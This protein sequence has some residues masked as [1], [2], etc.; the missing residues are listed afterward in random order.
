MLSMRR[1]VKG[2]QQ[3]LDLSCWDV[4]GAV[5]FSV[6]PWGSFEGKFE[7]CVGWSPNLFVITHFH[8][9]CFEILPE[10]KPIKS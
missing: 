5:F 2:L 7:H 1:K 10:L 9:V 8:S 4:R 3:A 6:V